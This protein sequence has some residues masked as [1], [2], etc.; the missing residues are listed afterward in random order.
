MLKTN[1]LEQQRECETFKSKYEHY[2]QLY[3][4]NKTKFAKIEVDFQSKIKL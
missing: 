3:D 4:E 2:F 1:L